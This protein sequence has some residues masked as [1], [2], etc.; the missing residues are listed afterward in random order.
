MARPA[1]IAG[2]PAGKLGDALH[3]T[4]FGHPIHPMLVT[5]PIGTWTF[6]LALDLLAVLG[7]RPR[8]AARAAEIALKAGAAG[9]V[10]A[11]ATG[12]ADWQHVNGRD[13]RVGLVHAIVNSTALA[14][15]LTSIVLRGRGRRNEG[16]LASAA[17]WACM[18]LGGY[19]GGH[20]V[21][22]RRIGSDHAD[23]SP[24]PRDFTPVLPL[25]EL[26]EDRP[27]RVEVWDEHARQA[28]GIVLVRHRG[29]VRAMGAR[30][31]H[32]GGPLDQG[33]VLNGELVCPWHGSRY[34][35]ATGWPSSGP[36]TCPQ[37]RYEVRVTGG[38]IEIRR[39]QE[40]G[41]DAVTAARLDAKPARQAAAGSGA[42]QG[43]KA[44]EVLVEHHQLL[45]RLF[46]TIRA[47]PAED[48][49]RRDLMRTLA[50]ELEIHEQIE[51]HIFYPA[52][53][54]VSE[55]VPVAHSEHRQLSDLLAMT[56]KLNT[57]SPEFEAHLRALHA[58]V[59]HHAGSEER[60]MFLHAQRL[61][62]ARL[63]ELGQALETM[64]EEQRTSRFQSAFRDLK[65]RL[66]EG[67]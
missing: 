34:D 39:E 46:E 48:P 24:E 38:M 1:Q 53:Q 51:D 7:L 65:I 56:L 41:D 64:L 29:R 57:A 25:A 5:I 2:R 10:A 18:F 13:R 35:L 63:R 16:R 62:D 12:M 50:S 22:R 47:M 23:R 49:Q 66:L 8:G 14:L 55:D 30:C 3:G 27:R 40:R 19:L 11:A 4:W 36:S 28:I 6:A 26:E 33:W 58:A 32:L 59:D 60:S 9:A 21:Y 31:S 15:N 67:L 44:D 61:G 54:P 42:P 45:R 43:R 52:V 20:M 17:G 37:P